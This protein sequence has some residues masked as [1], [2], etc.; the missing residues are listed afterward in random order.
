MQPFDR[1]FPRK[2]KGEIEK[3]LS[4]SFQLHHRMDFPR[5]VVGKMASPV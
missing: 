2:G 5:C 4:E 1:F 3:R